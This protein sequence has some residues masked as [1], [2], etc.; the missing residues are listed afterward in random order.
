MPAGAPHAVEVTPIRPL[1]GT[2]SGSAA[3]GTP[4]RSQSSGSQ[5]RVRMSHSM[6]RLAL[7]T[8]VAKTSP[9]VRFQISHASMVPRARSSSTGMSRCSSIQANLVP[10]KYGSRTRP[11]RSRT[12]GRWPSASSRSQRCAV[13][14]SCHTIALPYGT[15]VVRFQAT[16][17]SRW[18]VM[19]IAPTRSRPTSR[20]DVVEGLDDGRP[21]LLR[22]VFD[23]AG[24]GVVLRELAVRRNRRCVADEHGP[25]PDAGRTGVDGD[26]TVS[27]RHG[28]QC[29][30]AATR[31]RL[32][33]VA[34][35]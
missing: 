15:P 5:V 16:T 12:S 17:V 31:L 8:S 35:A 10:E 9:P 19:P 20:D 32:R 25:T 21:D 34:A 11:V 18:F 1:D 22:I 3:I 29:R 33:S 30:S 6:V 13:R 28:R 26:D 7:V 14:R 27:V 4:S 2:I 24:F 23:P